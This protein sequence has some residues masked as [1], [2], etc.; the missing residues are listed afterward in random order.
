MAH[1]QL[2][3]SI[4]EVV[5]EYAAAKKAIEEDSRFA[6]VDSHLFRQS[7]TNA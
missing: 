3:K 4:E 5:R 7:L 2:G 6:H 1:S